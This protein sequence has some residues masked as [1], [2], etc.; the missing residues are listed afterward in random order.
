MRV[1][2]VHVH[3]HVDDVHAGEL[4]VVRGVVAV[5]LEE[6]VGGGGLVARAQLLL[7]VVHLQRRLGVVGVVLLA[8]LPG[9]ELRGVVDRAAVPLVV[10]EGG[11]LAED[12]EVLGGLGAELLGDALLDGGQEAAVPGGARDVYGRVDPE[13]VDAHVDVLV[14]GADQVVLDGR[15]LGV[16]VGEVLVQPART[17][18]LALPVADPA[19]VVERSGEHAGSGARP[20][21]VVQGVALGALAAGRLAPVEAGV[22]GGF[23]RRPQ[24]AVV[25][26]L[27]ALGLDGQAVVLEAVVLL[28]VV[29]AP[30]GVPDAVHGRRVQPLG[31]P[32]GGVVVD[33]VLVDLHALGV[34]RVDQVLVGGAG[35]L[36]A[37]VDLVEVVAVIAVVVVIGAVEDD[38]GDPHGGEAEGLDVVELLD[39]ALEVAAEH[40]VVVGRVAR[41]HML[42]AAA[43]VGA[44]AVVEA[45]GEDEVDRVLARVGAEWSTGRRSVGLLTR[46][47]LGGSRGG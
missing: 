43:V 20:L 35:G 18:V 15:V 7:V 44:V 37:G 9:V 4:R 27:A 21:A 14:V 8:L 32:A 31:S 11:D 13:A 34:G 38:R 40:G 16:E 23:G 3:P 5:A 26:G 12:E 10:D 19:L 1:T 42:A 24:V 22:A 47:D 45:G 25:V 2:E 6:G 33:D 39:Q 17:G 46:G 29:P 41:L 36:Q 28:V 30:L